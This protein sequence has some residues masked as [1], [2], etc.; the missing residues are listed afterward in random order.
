MV[1]F[2]SSSDHK[3]HAI[4]WMLGH[5][6]LTSFWR[7]VTEV[8]GGRALIEAKAN[9]LTHA[10]TDESSPI[11]NLN[12]L[13]EQL[14]KDYATKQVHIKTSEELNDDLH[15]LSTAGLIELEPTFEEY[16]KGEHIE[17]DILTYLKQGTVE[18]EPN[19]FDVKDK[20]DA[21]IHKFVLVLK[22]HD[23]E[24]E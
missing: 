17:H 19:F 18:F 7:Y 3:I 2:N 6:N 11:Q 21:V 5:T 10:I 24:E 16:L 14:K 8:V 15:Y 9:T 13:I 20:D 22:V 1:F 4:A 12:G 23:K